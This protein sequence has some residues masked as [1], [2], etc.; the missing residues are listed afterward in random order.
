MFID[1]LSVSQEH[2]HDLPVVCDVYTLTI[3]ANSHEVLTTRQPR[4]K[5]QGSFSSSIVISVQG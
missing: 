2:D 3:D 1:W 5:H 4:F